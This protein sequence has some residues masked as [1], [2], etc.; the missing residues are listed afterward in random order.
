MART[1]SPQYPAIGLKEAVEK[2]TEVYWKGLPKQ[3]A[4]RGDRTAYGVQ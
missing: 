2:I 3:I 1:R 4:A